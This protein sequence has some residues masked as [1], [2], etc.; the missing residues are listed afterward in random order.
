MWITFYPNLETRIVLE[1][2]TIEGE[3]PV[4]VTEWILVEKSTIHWI[5]DGNMGG[6]NS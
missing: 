5:L 1:Q 2:T 6:I 4:E 3:S